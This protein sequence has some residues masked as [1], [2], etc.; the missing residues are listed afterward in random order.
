MV[1][2]R[3]VPN[4]L[5]FFNKSLKCGFFVSTYACFTFFP[6]SFS[7]LEVYL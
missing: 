3:M 4:Y 5:D 7:Y 1:V 6:S 2:I